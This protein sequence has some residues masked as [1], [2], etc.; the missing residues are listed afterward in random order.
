M[1]KLA[2]AIGSLL[3]LASSAMAYPRDYPEQ[4]RTPYAERNVQA[5]PN[6]MAFRIGVYGNMGYSGYAMGDENQYIDR[7]NYDSVSMGGK[8]LSSING[9]FT[10]GLGMTFGFSEYFQM[11]FEYEGLSAESRGTLVPGETV[12]ISLPASEFG[13][14]IKL[15]LPVEDRWLLSFGLGV[16][17][18]WV[19]NVTEKYLPG[20]HGRGQY[21]LRG[22][23]RHQAL[24]RGGIFFHTAFVRGS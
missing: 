13:G 16:Y 9:G 23:S 19:N 4:E 5:R 24:V 6:D 20:R 8:T 15:G 12:A 2:L 10:G 11:G 18:L 3:V 22:N 17:N 7:L 14:F 1:K 21:V